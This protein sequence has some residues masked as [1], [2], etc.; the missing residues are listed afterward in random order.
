MFKS[1]LRTLPSL[2]GNFSLCCNLNNITKID[3]DH[4]VCFVK[5]A[6][7]LPLQNSLYSKNI[8]IDLLNGDYCND[9]GRFYDEYKD[10]FYSTN[11]SYIKNDYNIYDR[12]KPVRNRNISYEFGCSRQNINNYQFT[13]FAP[14]YIDNINDLPEYFV[15]NIKLGDTVKKEIKIHINSKS[16]KNILGHYLRKYLTKIDSKMIFL[17]NTEN[18]GVYYGIDVKNGSLAQYRNIKSGK[19]FNDYMSMYDFDNIINHGFED[20]NMICRQII[21]ISFSFNVDDFLT[22]IE[23]KFFTFTPIHIYGFWQKYNTILKFYDFDNNYSTI[24]NNVSFKDD[25]IQSLYDYS[26]GPKEFDETSFYNFHELKNISYKYHNKITRNFNKWKLNTTND[27]NPYITNSSFLF[28]NIGEI[29]NYYNF[30]MQNVASV[31]IINDS[32]WVPFNKQGIYM[33][34]PTLINEWFRSYMNNSSQW[35]NVIKNNTNISSLCTNKI[36]WSDVVNNETMFNSILYN[37]IDADKFGVFLKCDIKTVDKN[38][39]IYRCKYLYTHKLNEYELYNCSIYDYVNL[40]KYDKYKY[41]LFLTYVNDIVN[42]TYSKSSS[43][44]L[45]STKSVSFSDINKSFNYIDQDTF[46]NKGENNLF[47]THD[48]LLEKNNSTG[49]IIEFNP[50][51]NRWTKINKDD[52]VFKNYKAYISNYIKD[53]NNPIETY[54]LI[55]NDDIKRH[56]CEILYVFN[57][58]QTKKNSEQQYNITISIFDDNISYTCDNFYDTIINNKDTKNQFKNIINWIKDN[59]YVSHKSSSQKLNITSLNLDNLILYTREYNFYVRASFMPT[60]YIHLNNIETAGGH[61][62]YDKEYEYIN[63]HNDISDLKTEYFNKIETTK[64]MYVIFCN[65]SLLYQF[66]NNISFGLYKIQDLNDL[67]LINLLRREYESFKENINE[68]DLKTTKIYNLI[69]NLKCDYGLTVFGEYNLHIKQISINAKTN[70][71]AYSYTLMDA[72]EDFDDNVENTYIIVPIIKLTENVKNKLNDLF[73]EYTNEEKEYILDHNFYICTE[74]NEKHSFITQNLEEINNLILVDLIDSTNLYNTKEAFDFQTEYMDNY[75]SNVNNVYQTKNSQYFYNYCIELSDVENEIFRKELIKNSIKFILDWKFYNSKQFVSLY[76]QYG[77]KILIDSNIYR[78][79]HPVKKSEKEYEYIRPNLSIAAQLSSNIISDKVVFNYIS[80]LFITNK[81]LLIEFNNDN[82]LYSTLIDL[83]CNGNSIIEMR[84]VTNIIGEDNVNDKIDM[85][86]VYDTFTNI[87]YEKMLSN[88]E[89][90]DTIVRIINDCINIFNKIYFDDDIYH[91]NH[92]EF[93]NSYNTNTIQYSEETITHNNKKYLAYIIN[94]NIDASKNSFNINKSDNINYTF[95]K[96]NNCD[97]TEEYL[98]KNFKYICPLLQDNLFIKFI[99][100]YKQNIC[101]PRRIS[102]I[103]NLITEKYTATSTD[104]LSKFK[105]SM[106]YDGTLYKTKYTS[107]VIHSIFINRY[108]SFITPIL[109]EV[110]GE[111]DNMY[112]LKFKDKHAGYMNEDNLY[113][114]SKFNIQNNIPIIYYTD[115][116]TPIEIEQI[117]EKS[118]NYSKYYFIPNYIEI[119]INKNMTYSELLEYENE[120]IVKK[121]FID[122]ID[123]NYINKID[124]LDIKLFLYNKYNLQFVSEVVNQNMITNEKI[125]SLKYQFT[126]SN[127]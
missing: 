58:K 47:M 20:M 45:F 32:L 104:I 103:P 69:N 14:I 25:I 71:I 96:I 64:D 61:Y 2:T 4:Y 6:N 82:K 65:L 46:I 39:H 117:E 107:S 19:L 22:D 125:Y 90:A 78:Y 102:I 87:I 89:Y 16:D 127:D 110:N 28:S 92:V 41:D 7:A 97:I 126:L 99:N 26:I 12:H 74:N 8:N 63:M 50:I 98:V 113:M 23:K 100:H 13:F 38:K 15:I 120:N 30:P 40:Y 118:F 70:D 66:A 44:K 116:N 37:N 57:R 35:F 24:T 9:V 3:S 85:D 112:V 60:F 86:N 80:E 108:F 51:H 36:Y 75:V 76:N 83:S 62:E 79:I 122:Y 1:L 34:S 43:N 94:L 52:N 95:R 121:Y 29:V 91:I 101:I 42:N 55:T 115:V 114:I 119:Q 48:V 31:N 27:K 124:D 81:N 109:T 10:Y 68:S 18:H 56:I 53:N 21:P 72:N 93:F 54:E 123:K 88:N 106:S 33:Y 5:T 105:D 77:E 111:I 49:N 59:V 84:D 67:K 73:N 17:S 11:F